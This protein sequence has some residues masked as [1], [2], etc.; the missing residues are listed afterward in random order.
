MDSIELITEQLEVPLDRYSVFNSTKFEFDNGTT[1]FS[2]VAF[3]SVDS[4]S[5]FEPVP[6]SSEDAFGGLRYKRI[7]HQ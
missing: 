3:T 7:Q 4:T 2:E 5:S 6:F 1:M